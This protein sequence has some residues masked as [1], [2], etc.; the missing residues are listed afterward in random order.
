M[1]GL[2]IDRFIKL[3]IVYLLWIKKIK[4]VLAVSVFHANA[5]KIIVANAVS[6]LLANA[7]R[8]IKF[9]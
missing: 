4:P 7:S 3:T 1:I 2:R 6:A 5:K 8:L 9:I